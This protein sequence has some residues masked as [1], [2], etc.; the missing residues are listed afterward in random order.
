VQHEQLDA[1]PAELRDRS[2]ADQPDGAA[3]EPL[4][5]DG[6]AGVAALLFHEILVQAHV[7]HRLDVVVAE[8]V[9]VVVGGQDA[10]DVAGVV[11]DGAAEDVE[12]DGVGLALA[13]AFPDDDLADVRVV[14]AVH[15]LDAMREEL[16]R[17]RDDA[18]GA[19]G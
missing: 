17:I 13:D 4:V 18:A 3:A 10:V 7:N 11:G 2:R 15:L 14:G 19:E 1:G 6:A 16:V 12:A 9:A 8:L 5:T